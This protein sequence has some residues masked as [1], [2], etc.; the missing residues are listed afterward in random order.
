MNKKVI[1]T[2]VFLATV[3]FV[4][5]SP[6][7]AH[8]GRTDSSGCHT[9]KTN[10]Q[11]WGLSYGEY[12]CHGSKPAV[13]IYPTSTPTRKPTASIIKKVIKKPT[14]TTFKKSVKGSSVKKKTTPTPKSK[15]T[16]NCRKTCSNLTCAEAYFQLNQCGCSARDG[17][18][19]GVPCEAQCR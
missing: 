4:P 6:A 2:L 18:N 8:P 11:K 10:C 5:Y 19:D 12:H 1:F 9:C 15:Y 14:P 16:C 13:K 3:V 17:D 7:S